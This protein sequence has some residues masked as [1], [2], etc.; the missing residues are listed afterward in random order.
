MLHDVCDWRY[1]PAQ[2]ARFAPWPAGLPDPL[3]AAL[4]ARGV[5]QLYTHQASA[6]EAVLD[7]QH[8]V[9]VARAAGGKS[10]CFHLPILNGC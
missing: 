3:Q 9:V 7:R 1:A 4:Q 6:L 2:P 8:V 5:A 10:L